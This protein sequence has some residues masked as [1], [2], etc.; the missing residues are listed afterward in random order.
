[1][2]SG[3]GL[4]TPVAPQTVVPTETPPT[5]LASEHPLQTTT[6]GF[7]IGAHTPRYML[8]S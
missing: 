1:M 6:L 3:R 5:K 7:D 8:N 4:R 2:M